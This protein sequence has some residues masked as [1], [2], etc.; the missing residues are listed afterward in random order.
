[1]ESSLVH[2]TKNC[3]HTHETLR[4]WIKQHEQLLAVKNSLSAD[5]RQRLKGPF[6][7]KMHEEYNVN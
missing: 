4:L 7:S 6:P 2:C 3:L 5:A 1:M